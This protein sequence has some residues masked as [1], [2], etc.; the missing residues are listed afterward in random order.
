MKKYR[1]AFFGTPEFV[2]PVAE[3]LYQNEDL[4]VV[5][6][7]TEKPKGRGLK[8]FPSPVKTWAEEK[9][10]PVLEPAKLRDEAFLE[11]IKS[12]E[13]DLGVVFAYGKILPS[14]LLQTPRFG[15]WNLHASLLPKFRGASPIVYAIL[16]GEKETGIT[17]MQMDEG[18]DTGPILLQER[19]EIAEDE[20]TPSLTEKLKNLAVVAL[21]KALK[22]HKEG[23]LVPQ[24]QEHDKATYAP[25]LKKEDGFFNWDEDALIIERKV[26]AFQP[27]PSA[28][29]YYQGKILKVY[30]AKNIDIEEAKGSPGEVL[31]ISKEG[32]WVSCGKGALLLEEVQLEGKKRISAYEFALGQR[33]KKGDNLQ[34]N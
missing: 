14:G 28:W 3:Y 2:I 32:V 25:L 13:L 33:L 4:V 23:K 1:V 31:K 30:K 12:F 5:V 9:G 29:T 11:S 19:I 26:R 17:V 24:P 8:P 7:Q 20:T 21:D 22:L 18:M 15:F 27:W 34:F 6:T 10:L 16:T